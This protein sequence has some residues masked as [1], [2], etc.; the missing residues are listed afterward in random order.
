VALDTLGPER[1]LAATGVSPSLPQRELRSVRELAESLGASVELVAT[2]ELD[3]PN[4]AANPANRCYFCK[5]ELYTRLQDLAT[6]R[7]FR[8]IANGT[9]TDDL[10]DFRPGLTAAKQWN[11]RSPL[12]EAGLSKSEV[13][14]LAR[15]LDL[16]NWDKPALACLSSRVAYGT[17]VTLGVLSQIEKAEAYLYDK[18]LT[19]F[20]VRHHQKLARIEV[21]LNDLSR[22]VTEPLRSQIVGAFKELGYAY[23]TIDLQGFRSGSGNEVLRS[24]EQK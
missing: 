1:V 24:V 19:N 6:R 9:N 8:S 14:E 3:N 17:P 4:Y 16:P 5:T 13:R 21:S 2:S 12:V 15:E 7:S 18:G 23:V 22:I 11:I 10:G 20:R